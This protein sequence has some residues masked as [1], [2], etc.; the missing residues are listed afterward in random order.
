MSPSPL[1]PLLILWTG[2][3]L[4]LFIDGRR[5]PAAATALVILLAAASSATVLLVDVV[6]DGPL[7]LVTGG[8][9]PGV[10]I[11]LRADALGGFF[12]AV[13][14]YGIAGAL[15][16][17]LLEGIRSRVL[18]A[19]LLLL[20]AGLTGLFLTSDIFTFYVFFEVAMVA[21]FVVAA[22]G[23]GRSELSAA[24]VF[25]LVNLVGSAFF[26]TAIAALYRISGTLD[27]AGVAAAVTEETG[28]SLLISTLVFVALG[29]KVG[30]FPLHFWL[31]AVYRGARPAAA[32]VLSGAVANIGSYG[33]IRLGPGLFP[34]ALAAARPPLFVLGVAS[35]LYGALLASSRRDLREVIG[36]SAIGQAGYVVLALAAG[37]QAALAAAALYAGVNALNKVL[38]FLAADLR[39]PAV[40]AVFAV[41]AFSVAGAPPT[42]GFLGKVE[43]FRLALGDGPLWMAALVLA[44]AA[45][46]FVYMFQALQHG[47]WRDAAQG[48]ASALTT[49][50]AVSLM[51]AALLALG[52]WPEAL[53]RLAGAAAGVALEGP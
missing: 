39:G 27:M 41:G 53:L 9:P 35:V 50:V 34:D 19:V 33:L 46:S 20:G 52:I 21:S 22:Y 7:E 48:P 47:Y 16:F 42:P 45:L 28:T 13:S 24:T 29:L 37:G 43:L 31:P 11:R 49:R 18:P 23:G 8:W 14:L 5:R 30:L 6:R 15:L 4:F 51:A 26:L 3:A 1:A 12:T 36:Y 10:G 25:A 2:G 38:L 32:A 17:E 44:G 40:G